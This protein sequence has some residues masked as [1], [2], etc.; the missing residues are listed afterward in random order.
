M[1]KDINFKDV[2]GYLLKNGEDFR[3]MFNGDEYMNIG[4]TL[5]RNGLEFDLKDI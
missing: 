3:I 4:E 5:Y 1:N 2:M